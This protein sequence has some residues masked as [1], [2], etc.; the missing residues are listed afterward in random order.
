[1]AGKI[2]KKLPNVGV[3]DLVLISK[4]TDDGIVENLKKRYDADLI[5][6]AIGPVLISVNPFKKLEIV[7]PEWI[8]MYKGKYRHELPPHIY[9][10]AEEAYRTMKSEVENHCVIISGESGAGK[11]EASKL[12]M[13]YIS[14]VSGNS[15]GVEYVKHV[16]LE[17]NPLLE[18]FGN[19]KTLRNNN[20]SRF[21]KYF[22]IQFN[23]YG[24]PSGGKITNYLLEKSR[25]VYQIQGERSF[26]IFYQ[27]LAGAGDREKQDLGLWAPENYTYLYES[28][29]YTIEGVDDRKEFQDVKH[30]MD[31][32]GIS[33]QDQSD[34]WRLVAGILHVGNISF[35]E[36]QKGNAQVADKQAV[37]TAAGMLAVDPTALMNAIVSRVMQ[38]GGAGGRS[39]VYNVPQN[40]EQA[41][42]ARDALSKSIYDRIFDWLVVQ[43]NTALQKGGSQA[44]TVIG[45]LDIFGF[46]IFKHNGFE[47][48]CINF[49]NEKLQQYFIEL[50]LKT[51]QE[52]YVRE[53]IKWEPIKYFN[54]QIVVDLIEGKK[55]PGIFLVLDDICATIHAQAGNQ[56]DLKFLQKLNFASN[57]H[58]RGLDTA[59]QVKH[60]AGEVTY[61]VSG[62]SDKNK[63]TLFPDLIEVMQASGMGFLVS[64]FPDDVSGT[65]KKRPTTAAFKIRD[66]AAKLMATLSQCSPHYVRCIKPNESK[67]PRDY[68]VARVK[69]QVQYLG[70]R[71]NVNV[72]RAGFAYR[73]EF[74]RFLRRYKKLSGKTYGM[75]GEWSGDARDG[76]STILNDLGIP[77]DQWQLGKTK[78]FVRYPETLFHLEELLDRRDYECVS[79]IQKAWKHWKLRKVSLEQKAA[80]SDL[81]RGKKER[82]RNS[83]GRK[84]EADYLNYTD[85]FGLQEVVTQQY[86]GEAVMFAD[87]VS[88]L[89]RRSKPERRDLVITN[90]ALYF[91]MRQKVGNSVSYKMTR[92]SDINQ[93]RGVSVST[94]ADN[95]VAIHVERDDVFFENERK[96]ELI[97][98]LREQYKLLTRSE[99]QVTFSDSI[100]LTIKTGDSRIIKYEKNESAGSTPSMKKA[101]KNLIVGVATG[102]PRDT[103]TAPKNLG[104][105]SG[106][107]GGGAK[108]KPIGGMGGGG[109]GAGRGAGAGGA[110]RAAP[111]Q[112]SYAQQPA[113]AAV[114][115]PVSSVGRGAAAGAGA[116]AGR[117]AGAAAVGAGR[118]VGAGV[119]AAAAAGAGRGGGVGAGRGGPAAPKPKA[120]APARPK[121]VAQFDYD[122]GTP[123]EL[124]FREGDVIFILQKDPGGWWEGELN[125][126]KGWIPANY[127]QEQ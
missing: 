43:V 34:I 7:G 62:F 65:Q 70:L 69:H 33:K 102:L 12:I 87:Q 13:Q 49:V 10:L 45:V 24:D 74:A 91:A 48:F 118:G 52:E 8:E 2:K 21:G 42:A 105:R 111:T 46:E 75:W 80:I 56:T 68:D 19:A 1:M 114:E 83:V 17:S 37:D 3:D 47:Q 95:Y 119:A 57:I 40:V 122:A 78:I 113:A 77:A 22:E 30:A 53:G 120:A 76:C 99:L 58:F 31:T 104:G 93:I 61:E 82:Q 72:K 27:L 4:I 85:N 63:D 55:P 94:M 16:I 67:K 92:R 90:K 86:V 71:E 125:G 39:S 88:K 81:F 66:S 15:E 79:R 51:E 14:A 73:A 5:Y 32:I 115:R 126:R 26:H 127:V 106:G 117:G 28:Q 107:G 41:S 124:S 112:S 121:A 20:S 64:L 44:R 23:N 60:Y 18:A 36:N 98:V 103:D 110:G 101:G 54:N 116:G 109:G 25:V 9:A 100:T 97:Q 35:K 29:C 59:F 123:D 38:T 11:T 96:T 108:P 84:F 6:T 50:T 89:N